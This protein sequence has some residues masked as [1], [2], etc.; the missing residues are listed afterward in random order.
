[1]KITPVILL[2]S[3]LA[4]GAAQDVN[5]DDEGTEYFD[6]TS[7]TCVCKDGWTTAESTPQDRVYCNLYTAGDDGNGAVDCGGQ[8]QDPD[9]VS[10]LQ[11]ESST[12]FSTGGMSMTVLLFTALIVLLSCSCLGCVYAKTGRIP[13]CCDCCFPLSAPKKDGGERETA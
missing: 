7:L 5:C 3:V 9:C 1:M 12:T 2:L 11:D 6:E 10:G 8:E 4:V 13:I